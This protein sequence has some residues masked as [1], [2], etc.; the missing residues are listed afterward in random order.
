MNKPSWVPE[1]GNPPEYYKW[2]FRQNFRATLYSGGA[3]HLRLS[4]E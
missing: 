3:I 2:L 1:P 4:I